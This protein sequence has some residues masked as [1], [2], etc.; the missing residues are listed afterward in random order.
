MIFYIHIQKKSPHVT[1]PCKM[2]RLIILNI[3]KQ[4]IKTFNFRSLFEISY[5]SA[6]VVLPFFHS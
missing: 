6:L 5:H 3:L 1:T 2:I 4:H